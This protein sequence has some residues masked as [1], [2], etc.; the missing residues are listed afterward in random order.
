ML[1]PAITCP[2]CNIEIKLTESL[3]APL[4]EA[5]RRE[6]EIRL[7]QKDAGI[8]KKEAMLRDREAAIVRA[9]E[10]IDQELAAKLL[11][12]RGKIAA[13]EARK[14]K[15]SLA[16]DLEQ[17]AT[18]IAE[19]QELLKEREIKLAEA[20]KSQAE[21]LRKQRELDDLKREAELTIEKRVQES[22][23][24]TREQAR[25]ETEE[26]LKFKVFEK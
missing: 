16:T 7:A 13:E 2:Q 12:E 15:L 1:E 11:Q 19:L 5:T 23:A 9:R 4:I 21:V 14:A 17:K 26:E 3:A 18:A 10:Q 25:K 22:L 24:A 6:F 8:A 20:Q